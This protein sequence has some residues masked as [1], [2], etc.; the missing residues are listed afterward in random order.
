MP[1]VGFEPTTPVFERAKTVH[2]LDR[3][4]TVIGHFSTLLT[5]NKFKTMLV[6]TLLKNLTTCFLYIYNIVAG[7]Q[8]NRIWSHYYATV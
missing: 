3:T 2:A 6:A 5:L 8:G 1:R 7:C 4:V